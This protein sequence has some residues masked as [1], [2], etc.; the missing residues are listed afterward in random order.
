MTAVRN[1]YVAIADGTRREILDLLYEH[2]VAT[3][4]EIADEFE[5]VSRP[6]IL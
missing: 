6:A 2:E 3:A 1:A 4:G 5:G